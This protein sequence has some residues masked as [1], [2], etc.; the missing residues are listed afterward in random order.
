MI[1]V[2]EGHRSVIFTASHLCV[3]SSILVKC[4]QILSDIEAA[5]FTDPL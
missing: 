1:R 4:V 5:Y 2:S 3:Y